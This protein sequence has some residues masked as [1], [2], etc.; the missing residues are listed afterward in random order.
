MEEVKD[1]PEARSN[2]EITR[3]YNWIDI[4]K[5]TDALKNR[6]I[7]QLIKKDLFGDSREQI[8]FDDLNE[9]FESLRIRSQI[10]DSEDQNNC[11]LFE[12]P[13]DTLM[14]R[15]KNSHLTYKQKNWIYSQYTIGWKSM[16][17]LSQLTGVSISTIRSIIQDF[18]SNIVRSDIY[19]N[20]R[21]RKIIKSKKVMQWISKFVSNQ[22]GW[23]TAK[24]VQLQTKDQLLIS[25]P[26]H[27]IRKHLKNR[28]GLSYKRGNPRP[29][30][31]DIIRVKLLRRLLWV[32]IAKNISE[33]KIL[34]NIDK[35]SLTRGTTKNYSWLR[36]RNIV[37]YNQ[38]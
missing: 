23:F 32:R 27:Q 22:T 1:N 20:I 26:L 29:L 19:K 11:A 6:E 34:I 15:H 21:W 9:E 5:D 24:D 16:N 28:E 2:S 4:N 8:R 14:S 37:L 25:I 17:Q 38:H 31:L 36:E 18:N 7:R 3:E 12:D 13:F 35:S 10:C 30:N 33:I